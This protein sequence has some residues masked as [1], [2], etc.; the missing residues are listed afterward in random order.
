MSNIVPMFERNDVVRTTE[1][2][3]AWL[4][5]LADDLERERFLGTLAVVVSPSDENFYVRA[6]GR[7][8][9]TVAHMIGTLFAGAHAYANQ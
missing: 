5:A 7:P 1:D 9:T 4:R 8:G 6:C 2:A 3:V